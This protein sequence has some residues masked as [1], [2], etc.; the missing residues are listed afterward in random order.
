MPL[1]MRKG[2]NGSE[3]RRNHTTLNQM[4]WHIVSGEFDQQNRLYFRGKSLKYIL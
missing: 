3:V 4:K 2:T 1:K